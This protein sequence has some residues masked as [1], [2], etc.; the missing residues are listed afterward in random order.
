MR[1]YLP[2]LLVVVAAAGALHYRSRARAQVTG[3]APPALVPT[4]DAEQE[5]PLGEGEV[6]APFTTRM[7]HGGPARRHRASGRGPRTARVA[8]KAEVGS[9]VQAQLVSSPD[10]SVLYALTLGGELI[11]LDA[12]SGAIR[13]RRSEG[14]RLYGTPFVTDGGL[15][16]LG[17]DGG[18]VVAYT[19]GGA[20][21][22]K[23]EAEADCDVGV[24]YANGDFVTAC[25]TSLRVIASNGTLRAEALLPKKIFTAPAI[26]KGVV[27]VGAQDGRVRA[28]R[29][30]SLTP[31]WETSLGADVDG[32]VALADDGSVIVGTDA[33]EVVRLSPAGAITWRSKVGAYVRGALSIARNGDVLAGVMGNEPGLV[34]LEGESGRE[35][36]RFAT[37]GSGAAEFGVRGGAL[38]DDAGTLYFGAQDDHVYALSSGGRALFRHDMGADVDAPLLLLADGRLIAAADNGVVVCFAP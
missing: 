11:A 22:L 33:G 19:S 15:V 34:R 35:R 25:G 7:L 31:A 16:V 12:G 24:A 37:A 21:T 32:G 20:R 9:A 10:G 27:V 2:A 5:I 6:E 18:A 17:R 30:P 3:Q 28:F 14:E 1:A 26:A 8:W 36:F 13:W 23:L 29:L 38:E 4:G